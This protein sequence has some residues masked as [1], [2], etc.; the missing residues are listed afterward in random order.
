MDLGL[1][2]KTALVAASSKGLGYACA[3]ALSREGA[4]VTIC[5]RNQA[6][7]DRAAETIHTETGNQVLP[8]IADMSQAK[9]CQRVVQETISHFGTIHVLVTNNGGPPAGY[10]SDFEDEDWYQAVDQTLM[11]A[12]RLIRGALPVMKAQKWGR[13]LNI[14]SVSVKQPIDN[15]LLSNS[16]RPGVIGMART[17]ANQLAAEGI[18]INNVLPGPFATDRMQQLAA[19]TAERED[20]PL[21]QVLAELA[22]PIPTGRLGKPGELGALVAFLAS[23]QAAFITGTSILVDGG[24]YQGL[25]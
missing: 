16:L 19:A 13:I 25:M 11:S 6:E 20:R 15:L 9:D 22:N 8:V 12:V 10:F 1:N 18:T 2:G 5:A 21:D 24:R 3:L 7:L 17:L 14:T 4:Q 23:E